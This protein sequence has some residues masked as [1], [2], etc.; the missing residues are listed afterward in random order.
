MHKRT[1]GFF[2]FETKQNKT[3]TIQIS[4]ANNFTFTTSLKIKLYS[5]TIL[6]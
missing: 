4:L 2:F 3:G 5:E 6:I 1:N